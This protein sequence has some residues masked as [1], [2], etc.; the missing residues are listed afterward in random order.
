MLLQA[1]QLL[2]LLQ[3]KQLLLLLLQRELRVEPDPKG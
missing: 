1:Q 3:G 2:L